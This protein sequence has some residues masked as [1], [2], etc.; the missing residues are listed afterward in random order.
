MDYID[1]WVGK[2]SYNFVA[3]LAVELMT[4]M[5]LKCFHRMDIVALLED[6]S[7]KL[8]DLRLAGPAVD[9]YNVY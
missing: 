4:R 5:H 1:S 8:A 6:N 9:I 7:D 3:L 2:D